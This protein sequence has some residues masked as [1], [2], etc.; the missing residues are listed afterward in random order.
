M[1]T[2]LPGENG[3]F[4]QSVLLGRRDAISDRVDEDMRRSGVAHVM[5]V[6]GLHLSLVCGGVAALLRRG[7]AGRLVRFLAGTAACLAVMLVAGFTP[8]V[9]RGGIMMLL[10]L[11]SEL[12]RRRTDPFSSLAAAVVAM[13]VCNPY[14]LYSWSFLLSVGSMLS[15]LVF[16]PRLQR[17][18]LGWRKKRFPKADFADGVL[19]VV[20]VSLG[21]VVYTYPMLSVMFGGVAVYGVLG[22][23][24]ISP[25]VGVLMLLAALTALLGALGLGGAAAVVAFPTGLLAV[26]CRGAAHFVA[27]LP[28][29]WQPISHL[30]QIVWLVGAAL[31]LTLLVASPGRNPKRTGLTLLALALSLLAGIAVTAL[32]QKN[33][34]ELHTF[35]ESSSLVLVYQQQVVVVDADPAGAQRA[36]SLGKNQLIYTFEQNKAQQAALV[37]QEYAPQAAA[38]HNDTARE[39]SSY[40]PPG[41]ELYDLSQQVTAGGGLTLTVGEGYT[42]IETDG[43]RVLKL[44]DGYAIIENEGQPEAVDIIVDPEGMI[45]RTAQSDEKAVRTM[46]FRLD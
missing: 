35:E 31:V 42:L 45:Y 14:V 32:G 29:S 33:V 40:L 19:S 2:A 30:W 24:L 17:S 5:V 38:L 28:G 37:L 12:V 21:A 27:A 46:R 20:S 15:I 34:V 36:Q 1:T 7:G 16:V 26:F 9:T 10:T 11:L 41:T 23:L 18:L 44:L 4:V 39:I 8:S 13:G 6:S 25:V 43:L 22:N 3:T